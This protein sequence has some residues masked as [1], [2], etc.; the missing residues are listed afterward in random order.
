[1]VQRSRYIA[2]KKGEAMSYLQIRAEEV[3]EAQQTE[4][5]SRFAFTTKDPLRPGAEYA[6]AELPAIEKEFVQADTEIHQLLDGVDWKSLGGVPSAIQNELHE[7]DRLRGNPG[8]IR[9]TLKAYDKLI[10]GAVYKPD[11]VTFDSNRPGAIIAD[12]APKL[13]LARGMRGEIRRIV[14]RIK[15]HLADLDEWCRW[16]PLPK[17][18]ARPT[19]EKPK[20]KNGGVKI[21][22]E[23]SVFNDGPS[24][25]L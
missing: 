8:V 7:L 1:M 16:N 10:P 11:G 5:E 20:P 18:E 21:D 19:I 17:L 2:N 23:F 14:N 24:W 15:M 13:F 4:R 22:S 6:R 9:D 12:L 3:C 25:K